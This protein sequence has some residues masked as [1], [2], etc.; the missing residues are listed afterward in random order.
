MD[1]IENLELTDIQKE[2][3]RHLSSNNPQAAILCFQK[4]ISE[5]SSDSVSF[6]LLGI[7]YFASGDRDKGLEQF[8]LCSRLQT[9]GRPESEYLSNL[10]SILYENYLD[11]EAINIFHQIIKRYPDSDAAME[12]Q[13]LLNTM[14]DMESLNS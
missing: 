2:G 1:Q 3:I 7:A 13:I 8:E 10:A 12:A 11:Q 14:S 6:Y 4:T 9:F 5:N